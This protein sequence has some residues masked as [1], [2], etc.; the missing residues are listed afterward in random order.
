MSNPKA[1]KNRAIMSGL[2]FG[3]FA[4]LVGLEG[5]AFV[6]TL[7]AAVLT[8]GQVK[9]VFESIG[10]AFLAIGVIGIMFIDWGQSID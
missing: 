6:A 7:F 8:L 5:P 3:G 4:L 1:D 2:T 9:W 10:L